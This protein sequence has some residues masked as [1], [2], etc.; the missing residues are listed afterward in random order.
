MTQLFPE[1]F[2]DAPR[3]PGRRLPRPAARRAA[4]RGAGRRTRPGR[5]RAHPRRLQLR[6]LRARP[7]GP[8]RWA[9]SSSRGATW[10]AAATGCGMRTT[11]GERRVHVVY[12]RIDDEFLDP[13]H[14]RPDSVLGCPGI[15]N[16]AR[17]GQRHHRQ[18][19]RQRRRR[20]QARLHLRARPDPLL[21]RRG[22]DPRTT[23]RPTGSRTRDV[24]RVGAATTSTSWCSSRSTAPAARASSS[25]RRP[26]RRR[27]STLRATVRAD[28]RGWIAQ[29]PVALS[30]APTLVGD[31]IAPRHVDLRPFAVN[32]GDDVWVL[33]GGLTRVAL[34]EGA[35]VVNSSQG[36][37][38]KDTWVL[39]AEQAPLRPA[40]WSR[41]SPSDPWSRPRRRPVV[42]AAR[43]EPPLSDTAP[44]R[45][46]P[47]RRAQRSAVGPTDAEPDRGVA[48]L[49]RPLRR[50]RRRHRPHPRRV[51]PPLLEDPWVDEAAACRRCS[52][53]LGVAGPRG[54]QRHR[55]PCST[56]SP[57]TRRT[58]ARSPAR[59]YA[60]RENARGARETISTEM[61]EAL[62]V[63]WHAFPQQRR[64]AQRLRP[65]RAFSASCGSARPWST[66][67]ADSTMSRDD[68]WRFLVLG[69]SLERA[70]M[71][72]RLLVDA[73]AARR[74]CAVLDDA[75]A[76]LR[77]GR[78][79]PAHLPRRRA[80]RSRSR[81]SCCWTGSS[82][83]R[84]STRCATAEGCLRELDPDVARAGVGDTEP[85]DHRPGPD[86]AGVRRHRRPARRPARA[87]RALQRPASRRRARSR[88]A[89]SSTGTR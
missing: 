82:R 50:A 33:P 63:T 27:W 14:F 15:L 20:R 16:A 84:C 86:R 68:G 87:A 75:A 78:D 9:S 40:G 59:W 47:R 39:A 29:R 42:A 69:R 85:P 32:D 12:R 72:A 23:S 36:G 48:V 55:A 37:G 21:P 61:W 3:A 51:R 57:S 43:G 79:L 19:R 52:R 81:S 30:T 67:L 88:P 26:T 34:P 45:P 31:R 58:R 7:A 28:P 54:R 38:S 49:D 8:A 80:T 60:A 35:L 83:A 73:G 53:I 70:D 4:G 1:L 6:L 66:G 62:N 17:A 10:S 46:R 13:L 2:A 76:R 41:R 18:R 74:P 77:R 24:L 5:R 44:A 25:G 64:A 11:Q 56:C 65:A 22:A 71:T 89:T